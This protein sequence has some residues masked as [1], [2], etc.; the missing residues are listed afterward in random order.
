[1]SD[2]TESQAD[3]ARRI[4]VTRQRVGA[5]RKQGMPGS[6]KGIPVQAAL[7]WIKSNISAR[8]TA[9]DANSVDLVEARRLKILA[10]TELTNL[11]IQKEA[12]ALVNREEVRRA[13][14]AFSRQMRDKWLDFGNRHGAQI[15]AELNVEPVS[16]MAVLDQ[17]VRMQL[18]EIANTKPPLQD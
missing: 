14:V 5:M 18:D 13:L 16:L 2:L 3:F 11:Q 1:M 4:S 17:Y 7:A 6:A 9:S 10:D 12:G 8:S 15:A